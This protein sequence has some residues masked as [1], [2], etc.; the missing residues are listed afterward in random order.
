MKLVIVESP[1][2][3]D[4]ERNVAYARACMADCLQRGE[5]SYASHLLYTQ[6]GV[7]RDEVPE[8][9]KAGI[10]AG[11]AFRRIADVSAFYVDLGWSNGMYLGREHCEKTG[12]EYE[13]RKLGGI[14]EGVAAAV[15]RRGETR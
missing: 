9:R 7:L 13:I 6:P 3:G 15:Q 8:E 5:A 14:W 4:I 12:K 1:Y 2:A 10:E 11:F